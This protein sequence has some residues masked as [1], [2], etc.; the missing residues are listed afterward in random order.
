MKILIS[1][2]PLGLSREVVK[3]SGVKIESA[4]ECD[5]SLCR[6][7]LFDE[8]GNLHYVAP[9]CHLVERDANGE[10]RYYPVM[11][12]FPGTPSRLG[13]VDGELVG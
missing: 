2:L 11:C 9:H 3:E 6:Q 7:P 12:D 1:R 10:T 5:G 13:R 8:D 4:A